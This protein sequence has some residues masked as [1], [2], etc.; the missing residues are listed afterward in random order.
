MKD[1][2][3]KRAKDKLKKLEEVMLK[4]GQPF[5]AGGTFSVADAYAYIVLSWV[6]YLKIGPLSDYAKANAYYERIK[7]LDNVQAAHKRMETAPMQAV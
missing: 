3:A 4:D 5:L 1:F 7:A 2:L 6:D